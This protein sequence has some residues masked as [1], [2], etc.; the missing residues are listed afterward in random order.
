MGSRLFLALLLVPAIALAQPSPADRES[1]RA[2][3]DQGYA[4]YEKGELRAALEAFTAADA[5][6]RAPTTGLA[7]ARAQ[8]SLGMLVEARETAL[9]V[10]RIPQAPREPGPF[11]DARKAAQ[12]M[13]DELGAR[14]PQLRVVLKGGEAQL[15][16]DGASIP[17]AAISAARRLN[18]GR[19][20]IVARPA[21]GDP[22]EREIELVERDDKEMVI[23]VPLPRDTTAPPPPPPAPSSPSPTLA[24]V[25][26]GIAGVGVI[27]GSISG[28][29]ALSAK[30]SA[31]DGCA[32][33]R[34]PPATH[35]D[36]DRAETFGNVS[37][38]SFIVA[39]VG[40]LV[41]V[42]ALATRSSKTSTGIYVVPGGAIGRF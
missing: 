35:G 15:T 31:L 38:A 36:L 20:R 5:L 4:R 11:A 29:L 33:N 42:F 17:A 32:G 14:I 27:A 23:E 9:A 30:G 22:I 1:A 25:G 18:P 12:A 26:F 10:L 21:S 24:W 39:G 13:S 37:T 40:V 6:V 7:V 8:Q 16:I 19:H 34:C 3:M 41:G 28:V 2:L